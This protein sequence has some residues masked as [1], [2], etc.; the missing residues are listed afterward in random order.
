MRLYVLCSFNM[1]YQDIWSYSIVAGTNGSGW[2]YV[3]VIA[4]SPQYLMYGRSPPSFFS[5]KKKPGTMGR[6]SIEAVF[7]WD[8]CMG[9]IN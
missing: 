5:M 2:G 7:Y 1:V 6:P 4:L 3:I 9:T 8:V